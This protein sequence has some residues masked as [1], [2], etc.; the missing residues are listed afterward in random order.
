MLDTTKKVHE[1]AVLVGMGAEYSQA[2]ISGADAFEELRLLADTAGARVVGTLVQPRNEIS[3][4]YYIG[5]GK[6]EELKTLVEEVEADMV[7]FDHDLSPAQVANNEKLLSVKVIDRSGL[8]LDIF[9]LRARTRE[10]RT[11]V[12]LAQLKYF[13][14]RLTR[15]WTHLSRQQGGIGMRG[16][17]ETQIEVDRRRIRQRIDHLSNVLKKIERQQEIGRNSR[18]GL[19]RVALVGYTNA[20]KSTLLNALSGAEVPVENKLFKTLDSVTRQVCFGS[21]PDM[22][23]SDTVGFIRNLPHDLIASFSSTLS[24]VRDANLLLHVIDVT[25]PEWLEHAKVVENV[26]ADLG[27]ADTERIEVFNKIDAVGQG[28]E[29]DLLMRSKPDARFISAETGDGLDG[30]RDRIVRVLLRANPVITREFTPEDHVLLAS[31]YRLGTII[32][33]ATNNGNIVLTFS[34]PAPTASKLGLLDR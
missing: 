23:L 12:E 28:G 6:A 1:R 30:L 21:T 17:G 7:I 25:N 29:I 14:P 11:Q 8:I 4:T 33:T 26:L 13:L 32:E 34:L 3:P 24:E 31:V 15:H 2:L 10:A 18:K 22:L 20:G 16:P 19:F 27:T 9:A 5:S